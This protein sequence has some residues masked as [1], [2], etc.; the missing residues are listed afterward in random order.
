MKS[1]K[2][3]L[4]LDSDSLFKALVERFSFAESA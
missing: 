4:D 2:V 1:N 3:A